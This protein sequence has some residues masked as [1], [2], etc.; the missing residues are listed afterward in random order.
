MKIYFISHE[1]NWINCKANWNKYIFQVEE[2]FAWLQNILG[3]ITKQ[4]LHLN[5][6]NSPRS[7]KIKETFIGKYDYFTNVLNSEIILISVI[8]GWVLSFW[9][10]ITLWESKGL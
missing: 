9:V 4:L 5:I 1:W 6:G 10:N 7:F 8:Y 2:L 3:K